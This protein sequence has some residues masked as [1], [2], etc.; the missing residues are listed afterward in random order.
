M[1]G[2]SDGRSCES[3]NLT[4]FLISDEE[5]PPNDTPEST[6]LILLLVVPR[7]RPLLLPPRPVRV[8]MLSESLCFVVGRVVGK[9]LEWLDDV[10]VVEDDEDARL[11]CPCARDGEESENSLNLL[12][13]GTIAGGATSRGFVC[14][15][16]ER[17][18][19]SSCGR[20]SEGLAGGVRGR[21]DRTY[22][23]G[24]GPSGSDVTGFQKWPQT[25]KT[26]GSRGTTY[27][28]T[29]G[30]LMEGRC[31]KQGGRRCHPIYSLLGR[32]PIILM[33]TKRVVRIPNWTDCRRPQG[34]HSRTAHYEAVR[35]TPCARVR[36]NA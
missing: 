26:S 21:L 10:S 13:L 12:G 4:A 6:E 31:R 19:R 27:S 18:G 17:R 34:L 23:T 5:A 15:I 14:F 25:R 2:G 32:H 33:R 16:D 28:D 24:R 22:R 20:R 9:I 11:G 3:E 30:N 7:A 8:A 29:C 1:L 35:A 36:E